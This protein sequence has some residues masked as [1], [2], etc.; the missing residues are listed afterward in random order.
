MNIGQLETKLKE[1]APIDV[2]NFPTPILRMDNFQEKHGLDPVYIKRDELCENPGGNKVRHLKYLIGDAIRKQS[3]VF[4]ISGPIQSNF[5]TAAAMICNRYKF[6][7][8]LLHNSEEPK[9][10]LGNSLLNHLMGVERVF[11]GEIGF[12]ELEQKVFGLGKEL[13]S[14]GKN[15]YVFHTEESKG[16]AA[17]GYVECVIEMIKQCKEDGILIED[18][19]V[20]VGNGIFAAGVLYGNAILG[21]PFN[22]HLVSVEFEESIIINNMKKLISTLESLIEFRVGEDFYDRLNIYDEY[23]GKG[24]GDS[25]QESVDMILELAKTEGIFLE[26]VYTS[27]GFYGMY[28]L[29]KRGVVKS[30]GSCYIHSGGFPSLFVQM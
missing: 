14:K 23:R 21:E 16:I 3:D 12:P 19:F 9:E 8:I 15:P 27:K 26:K 18:I 25:T 29:L 22:I 4:V 28:D 24:W 13:V 11:V 5:C 30:K 10:N 17:L 2:G 7:C 20:P 6:P 1:Y